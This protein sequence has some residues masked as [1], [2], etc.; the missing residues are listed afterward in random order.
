MIAP[1]NFADTS[2]AGFRMV[3]IIEVL[4]RCTAPVSTGSLA[5]TLADYGKQ[6]SKQTVLRDLSLLQSRGWVER[7]GGDRRGSTVHWRWSGLQPRQTA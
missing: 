2:H 5:L 1:A 3:L 7:I 6:P 4:Q